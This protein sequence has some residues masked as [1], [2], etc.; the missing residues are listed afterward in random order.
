MLHI[1]T[2]VLKT[3]YSE[4]S[5]FNDYPLVI[6]GHSLG[7]GCA[8]ILSL[9]LRPSFPSLQCF[10]F[11]P[12]GCVFDEEI[13]AVCDEFVISFVRHDD[14]V[15]RLSYHN[16]ET[17]RDEFFD[18]FARIKVPK[19]KLF[20]HLRTPY[21]ERFVALRN[22][23]VLR[24]KEQIPTD[25]RFWQQRIQFNNERED[26]NS[27]KIQLFIPGKIVHLVDTSGS[28]NYIPYWAERGEFAQLEI[29]K[30]MLSD[31]GIHELPE[32]LSDTRLGGANTVSLAFHN[33]PLIYTDDEDVSEADVRL[34][35]CC[36]NPY[37]KLPI[38]LALLGLVASALENTAA[39]DCDFFRATFD[40]MVD[41]FNGNVTMRFGIYSFGI[42]DCSNS[43]G[44]CDRAEDFTDQ[45]VTY[46][47]DFVV[48]GYLL[49]SRA[50]LFLASLIAILANFMVYVSMCWIFK[51]RVW[52]VITAMY[53]LTTLFGGLGLIFKRELV[54]C[55]EPLVSCHIGTNASMQILACCMYF[56][57]AVG[58]GYL[59]KT[60]KRSD[61]DGGECETNGSSYPTTL[62]RNTSTQATSWQ[63]ED[64]H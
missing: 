40:P 64:R 14:L 50:F 18:A 27:D 47:P 36:S 52:A 32:I 48:D 33:A 39:S 54:W 1:R 19:I 60:G 55:D 59:A 13:S 4:Q 23:K 21:S 62:S 34:F 16:L 30:R 20:Y 46:P 35:S 38:V 63:L 25:T 12:P 53:L 11:E 7:A 42:H 37:G 61:V 6:C 22:S 8:I 56:L 3:L 2:K 29:S 28:G 51:E 57:L 41:G 31:H 24:P 5:P 15:P 44:P 17:L 45:C 10:A 43:T 26:K 49:A 9:M 58:S